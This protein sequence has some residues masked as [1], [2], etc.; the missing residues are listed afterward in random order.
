MTLDE[1]QQTEKSIATLG[2]ACELAARVIVEV[3]G[4]D[5]SNSIN[6]TNLTLDLVSKTALARFQK[7]LRLSA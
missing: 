6:G 4:N 1:F 7:N 3:A 5:I 2:N